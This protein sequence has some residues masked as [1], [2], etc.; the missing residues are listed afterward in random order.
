MLFL[1]LNSYIQFSYRLNSLCNLISLKEFINHEI[2][3]NEPQMHECIAHALQFTR[4]S[5]PNYCIK[6]MFIRICV[7]KKRSHAM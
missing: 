1:S 5:S 6:L 4:M 2:Q 7:S 3:A